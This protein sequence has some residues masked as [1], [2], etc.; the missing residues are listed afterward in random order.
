MGEVRILENSCLDRKQL[1]KMERYFFVFLISFYF[2]LS[3]FEI[4]NLKEIRI[5]CNIILFRIKQRY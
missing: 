2:I 3:P 4:I 5:M 1:I